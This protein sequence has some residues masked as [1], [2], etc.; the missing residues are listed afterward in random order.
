M[1][2]AVSDFYHEITSEES[3]KHFFEDISVRALE[4]HQLKLFK[5]IYGP[6]EE[7][8]NQA[9]Y[10][11]FILATH[12]RLFRDQGLT[13][14]HFD[15]VAGCLIR[16]F[17]GQLYSQELIDEALSELAPLRVVFDYGAQVA[18][19]EKSYTIQQIRNLPTA[20]AATIGTNQPMLLPDPAWVEVPTWMTETL[21]TYSSNPVVRAW[22]KM[23]T[24]RFI[25]D[26]TIADTFLAMPY[27]N[28]HVYA[29]SLLQLA[30]LP[31]GEDPSD[32]LDI[33]KYPRGPNHSAMASVLWLRMVVQFALTAGAMHMKDNVAEHAVH[34]LLSYESLFKPGVAKMAGGRNIGHIRR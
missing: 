14:E 1:I 10:F 12:T 11:D 32:L 19:K 23:L 22:T 33:L 17:Q 24:D 4:V 2:L 8:P 15:T 9:E 26:V 27:W 31:V 5:T 28:H 3:L 7:K 21:T 25:G 29:A 34:Q 20:S 6:V 30:L 13:A 16:A 18:A